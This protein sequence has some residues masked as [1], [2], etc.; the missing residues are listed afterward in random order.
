MLE[1]GEQNV[2]V[3]PYAV[4]ATADKGIEVRS[5]RLGERGRGGMSAFKRWE[6]DGVVAAGCLAYPMCLVWG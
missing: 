6:G 2:G 1:K 3:L 4:R 5:Q